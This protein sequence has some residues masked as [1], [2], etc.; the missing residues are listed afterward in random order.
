MYRVV[1]AGIAAPTLTV[2]QG[3]QGKKERFEHLLYN[4]LLLRDHSV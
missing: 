2:M 1:Y 3:F 4:F